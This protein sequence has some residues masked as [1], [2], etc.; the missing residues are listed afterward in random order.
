APA[1][2]NLPFYLGF[3]LLGGLYLALIVAML[4]ADLNFTTAGDILRALRDRDIQY[5]IRLS[6]LSSSIT[7]ILSLWVAVPLG[8]LLAR[9]RFW[10]RPV[11]D[12]FLDIPIVLP[13][14]VVGLSLLI[15]FQTSFGSWIQR[16]I[17][18]TYAVPSVI[19]AQ[20]SVTAAF[21]ARTM[22]VTF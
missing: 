4:V 22:R 1:R 13:P 10:G 12:T 14:V 2:S 11:I 7:T 9:T 21:A 3:G 5:S 8:Y 17:P 19:L 6:L 16:Y 15:L 18:I 20:F